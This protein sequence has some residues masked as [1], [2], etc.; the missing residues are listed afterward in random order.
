MDVL[1]KY[2]DVRGDLRDVAVATVRARRVQ[3]GNMILP[4]LDAFAVEIVATF[5]SHCVDAFDTFFQT[6]RADECHVLCMFVVCV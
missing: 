5:D 2:A 1:R 3:C 6:N 4:F